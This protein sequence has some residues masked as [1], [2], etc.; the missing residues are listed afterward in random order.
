MKLRKENIFI[1]NYTCYSDLLEMF[2]NN[3][4][5][6]IGNNTGGDVDYDVIRKYRLG[7]LVAMCVFG[8]MGILGNL[9]MFLVAYK[10]EKMKTVNNR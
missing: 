5:F 7:V 8:V 6:E 1:V 2:T 4:K 9:L 3:S 10:N